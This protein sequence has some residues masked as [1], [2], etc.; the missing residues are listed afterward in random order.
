ME[1]LTLDRVFL[2]YSVKKLRQMAARIDDCL[3][4]LS[5]E[6]IWMR[7]SDNENAI[8]N[9][10]LHLSGN[11]GQWIGAGVGGRPDTRN[12]DAEF[13]TT[14]QHT[15][16][17]LSGRLAAAVEEATVVLAGVPAERLCEP[18]AIQGYDVTVLECIYHVVEHFSGHTGQ[19]LYATKA[20]TGSDL[21]YY[22]HLRAPTHAQTTP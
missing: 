15:P 1:E 4:R 7:G 12:R 13:Q 21:G 14:G 17:E 5:A 18:V 9:L 3:G 11:V 16:A 8:G 22:A 2:D 10:V 6:Q 20:L 19:I